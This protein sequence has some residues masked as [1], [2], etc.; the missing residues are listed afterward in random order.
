MAIVARAA[1]KA[2][3]LQEL[4]LAQGPQRLERHSFVEFHHGVDRAVSATR[5]HVVHDVADEHAP[6]LAKE[7]RSSGCAIVETKSMKLTP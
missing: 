3:V 6:V 4:F 5:V 2:R 1:G 7:K